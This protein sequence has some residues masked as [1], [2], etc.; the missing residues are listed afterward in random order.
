[1]YFEFSS[2]EFIWCLVFGIWCFLDRLNP[3][4]HYIFGASDLLL[5]LSNGNRA[6]WQIGMG[7]K[8][9][10]ASLAEHR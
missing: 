5:Q 7:S 3:F 8:D 1:M 6:G 9:G 2:L 4:Q 10:N